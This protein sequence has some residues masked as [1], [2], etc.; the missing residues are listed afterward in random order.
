MLRKLL[1][2]LILTVLAFVFVGC[3]T[4]S[5]LGKD[6]SGAADAVHRQVFDASGQ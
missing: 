6:V 4:V 3:Q 2:V 5:G 1:F